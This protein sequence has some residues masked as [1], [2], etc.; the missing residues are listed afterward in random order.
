MLSGD[1]HKWSNAYD[2]ADLK[3]KIGL[4]KNKNLQSALDTSISKVRKELEARGGEE[5][6]KILDYILELN[7]TIYQKVIKTKF[8]TVEDLEILAEKLKSIQVQSRSSPNFGIGPEL[9]TIIYRIYNGVD[10]NIY[11]LVA[12]QKE[13]FTPN[14]IQKVI[15]QLPKLI[16]YVKRA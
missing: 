16:N 6:L 12:L 7:S 14:V 9:G 2:W 11:G 5:E 4:E 3:L 13:L 8:E 10:F 15:Q 1:S